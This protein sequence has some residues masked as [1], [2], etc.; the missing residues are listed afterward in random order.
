MGLIQVNL[1]CNSRVEAKGN[2]TCWLLI[3]E[4]YLELLLLDY[5]AKNLKYL[6]KD[7]INIILISVN[8]S[9]ITPYTY[10]P[11]SPLSCQPFSLILLLILN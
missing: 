1:D 6:S 3:S 4:G 11:H 5:I 7:H 8:C 2:L 10:G 9:A